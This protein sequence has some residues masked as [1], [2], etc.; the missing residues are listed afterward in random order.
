[1]FTCIYIYF[2]CCLFLVKCI[3]KFFFIEILRISAL[4]ASTVYL[5]MLSHSEQPFQVQLVGTGTGFGRHRRIRKGQHGM[6]FD[7]F[8]VR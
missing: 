8:S 5:D 2:R 6:G 4:Q 3:N 1:M 7:V